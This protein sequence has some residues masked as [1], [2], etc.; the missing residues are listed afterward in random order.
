M[1][2]YI[3][4]AVSIS[5][6][7]ENSILARQLA[8]VGRHYTCLFSYRIDDSITGQPVWVI[9]TTANSVLSTN[10]SISPHSCEITQNRQSNRTTG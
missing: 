4:T 7:A 2:L 5:D 8:R 9:D 10:R 3:H 1:D 6:Q